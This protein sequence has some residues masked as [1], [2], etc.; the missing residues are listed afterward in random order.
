MKI[1]GIIPARAGSKRLPGKNTK[2]LAGKP[3]V[4][5]AIEAALQSQRLDAVVVSSDDP[6][7]LQL[8]R[9]YPGVIALP[10]PAALAADTSPAIDYVQHVLA[11]LPDTYAII[12]ILQPTSP[13]TLAADIDGT[14]DKLLATGADSAVSVVGLDHMVHPVKLKT[15]QGDRLLPFLEDERGRMA[16]HELP[17]VYVRNCAVYATTSHTIETGEIIGPD[18]RGYIMPTERSADI[19]EG[20][21]FL[22]VE[23]LLSKANPV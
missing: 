16:A 5:Y 13:L 19:N 18:C 12:V 14:I 4:T 1:L 3:L 21:D 7:V 8:A 10:R 11:T 22:F 2:L 17:Q 15:M 6:V 23:F 9:D 20:I